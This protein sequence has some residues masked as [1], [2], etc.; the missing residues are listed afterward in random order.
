MLFV[1]K[2]KTAAESNWA[3]FW[4]TD[5]VMQHFH[6]LYQGSCRLDPDYTQE[7]TVGL[8]RDV[9]EI[10]ILESPSPTAVNNQCR[11]LPKKQSPL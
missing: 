3:G 7:K 1:A 6:D 4:G 5:V 10:Y 11:K 2:T 9:A 8:T